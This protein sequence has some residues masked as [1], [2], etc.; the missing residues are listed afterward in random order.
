MA[1][2]DPSFG[3]DYEIV[4]R[5]QAAAEE[6]EFYKNNKDAILAMAKVI[7]ASERFHE[8]LKFDF[9]SNSVSR[10]Q[11]EDYVA[12]QLIDQAAAIVSEVVHRSVYE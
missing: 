3:C 6:A 9:S 12:R 10:T 5:D 4:A 8:R 1:L 2:F 7:Y 11:F